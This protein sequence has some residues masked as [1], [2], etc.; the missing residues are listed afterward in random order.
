MN[1][2]Y[3]TL[4]QVFTIV[5][6]LGL[7]AIFWGTFV[8]AA[9]LI[10]R[11]VGRTR[12]SAWR[13]FAAAHGLTFQPGSFS[14]G[15]ARIVGV[16]R[17]R[18]IRIESYK[19]GKYTYTRVKVEA[20]KPDAEKS[21]EGAKA[22]AAS[23]TSQEVLNR[24]MPSGSIGI[25]GGKV[26]A[27]AGGQSLSYEHPGVMTNVDELHCVCNLL[28]DVMDGYPAVAAAGGAAVRPLE[29]ISRQ[30]GLLSGVAVR[31]MKDI[32]WITERQ[33]GDRAG[34]LLCP[35]CLAH[36]YQHRADGCRLCYQSREFIDCSRGVVAVLDSAWTGA[37][38]LRDGLLQVNWLA[39]RALFDFTMVQIV[40]ATDED[41]ER[42]A[43]QAGNDADPLRRPLY[44]GMR[45]VVNPACG[46][47]ENT[48][49]ILE[50]T[51]GRVEI[52]EPARDDES[53]ARSHSAGELRSLDARD[54]LQLAPVSHE[55]PTGLEASG[56]SGEWLEALD[57]E[58][59]AGP[60]DFEGHIDERAISGH[61]GDD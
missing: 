53:V 43:V 22:I 3:N 11:S 55:E 35:H 61:A 26:E 45:C 23:P 13:K 27:A 19:E 12:Q 6:G 7:Q 54:G 14:L 32:A 25:T 56:Q 49:R 15:G 28:S 33:L 37:Q 20:N 52:L 16:Y 38:D 5:A 4:M 47:S 60:A 50:S 17:G 1:D 36:F 40:Q 58:K 39:R 59:P 10:S 44:A 34:R 51:F 30:T 2:L 42:F 21:G 8:A 18:N 31:L 48:L 9:I 24:L 29:T 57:R 46:L 41:V